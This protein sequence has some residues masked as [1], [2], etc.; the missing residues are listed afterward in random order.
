MLDHTPE[1]ES[2]YLKVHMVTNSQKYTLDLPNHETKFYLYSVKFLC[3]KSCS[4][5]QPT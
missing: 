4:I 5:R 3:V 1:A 2:K